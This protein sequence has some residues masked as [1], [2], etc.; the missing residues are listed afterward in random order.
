MRK[1]LVF[2]LL[3]L[4][5]PLTFA[6]ILA[7]YTTKKQEK[8]RRTHV[9]DYGFVVRQD[10]TLGRGGYLKANLTTY[11]TDGLGGSVRWTN[12]SAGF[13]N[14]QEFTPEPPPG[15]LRIL[16]LGDSFTAG[17]RVGQQETFSFLLEQWVNQ[18]L[19]KSEVMVSE[20]EEPATALYY[21]NKFGLSY[22]PHIVLLGI[23]LGN[24]I[25]QAYLSKGKYSLKVDHNGVTIEP[26]PTKF[27]AK[28]YG[29]PEAYLQK[30]SYLQGELHD[31]Q[32]WFSKL[33]LMRG[34]FKNNEGIMSYF[35]VDPPKI[36]DYCNGLGV[37]MNPSPPPIEEGYQRLFEIILGFQKV[38]QQHN[39]FFAVQLFPQRFQ[40]QPLDWESAVDKY[41]LKKSGFDLLGP[42]KKIGQFCLEHKIIVIDPTQD[43]AK[44]YAISGKKMYLPFGDMHWN[45][46]GQ[47]AFFE[48]SLPVF[49]RLVQK[50]FQ[51]VQ[52]S[53]AKDVPQDKMPSGTIGHKSKSMTSGRPCGGES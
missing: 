20:I 17:Y 35:D 16:S 12:N 32:R 15:T 27:V 28:N 26:K 3:V 52:A 22:H 29:I 18:H 42:N 1:R 4:V 41:R 8:F 33:W 34:F 38:C 53:N 45:K 25:G 36:F 14:D 9:F 19:G 46:E 2:I 6:L 51:E 43:M 13:R 37:F 47:R 5:L 50:G 31:F 21:L 44:R 10:D 48:S 7:E 39:I 23:T 30:Q 24:D 11:V 49:A 40:V